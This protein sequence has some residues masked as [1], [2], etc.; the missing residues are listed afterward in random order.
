MLVNNN[1][2][3]ALKTPVRSVEG[4]VYVYNANGSTAHT[5]RHDDKLKEFT[6]ERIGDSSKFFGYGICQKANIK[7]LDP[8][9]EITLNTSQKMYPYFVNRSTGTA[10]SI[11]P[12]PYM[13]ITEVHRDENTNELS[14]T[15]YDPLYKATAHKV[16]ELSIEA[17][18][19]LGA[20]IVA[21]MEFLR[22]SDIYLVNI[23]EDDDLFQL[24]YAEGANF[25][26]SETIREALNAVAEATQTIYY[27]DRLNR[28]V[29][30]RLDVSGD[31]LLTIEKP[32]Y[33]TLETK[34]NRRLAT[35]V[36]VTELDPDGIPK[37][38]GETGSTQY[39]RDNPFWEKREREDL[40]VLVQNAI[41]AA[42]GLTINQFECNWRGN[43]LLEMGDKIDLVTKDGNTVTSY[44]L[45]D[46]VSY[47]GALS[48]KTR[49]SY[50]ESESESKSTPTTL[51]EAVKQTYAR[52]DRVNHEVE[53]VA[54]KADANESAIAAIKATT[55][56]I[57][58]S[59]ENIQSAADST[60][61]SLETLTKKVEATVTAEDVKLQIST[62]MEKGVDKVTTKTGF[63]FDENGLT[64]D[65]DD[66][67][68]KTTI[69]DDGM[70]VYK[71]DEEVLTANN[72]GVKATNLHA[73]TYL[74]IG[75]NS[76]IEDFGSDRTA[77][78][79]I[80]S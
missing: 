34:T 19:T 44:V 68:M 76:R 52:V 36:H 2:L 79:W 62:E 1:A 13:D 28:L 51:G 67:E 45:D 65:K 64:V 56:G 46:T 32:D 16:S 61:Q 38:T 39:V 35:I 12:Y 54:S 7:V 70:K 37:T 49:W 40:E 9:R 60:N 43:Y 50:T 57:T 29:L 80:G 75:T 69:S 31:A 6:I 78:F 5:F 42:G 24:E 25:E 27:V 15:C 41:N 33:I 66:S 53:L 59:V 22:L 14:I 4:R 26:G 30:K 23:R 11:F 3:A 20:F 72:E 18:Y 17:P 58:A 77:I 8:D 55:E 47:N 73:N 10:S 21:C 63:T 48:E 74:I 71:N